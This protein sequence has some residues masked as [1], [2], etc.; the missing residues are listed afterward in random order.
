MSDFKPRPPAPA[1]VEQNLVSKAVHAMP[2]DVLMHPM[3]LPM[4]LDYAAAQ[5]TRTI[6][7][8]LYE[9]VRQLAM[10]LNSGIYSCCQDGRHSPVE[11]SCIPGRQLKRALD[12]LEKALNL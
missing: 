3:P 11:P 4:R 7:I 10:E 9:E 5:L 1:I 6:P 2:P 12:D 8:R